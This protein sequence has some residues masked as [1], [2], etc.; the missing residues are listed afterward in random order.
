MSEPPAD[1]TLARQGAMHR[2]LSQFTASTVGY[3]RNNDR[4]QD[5][6]A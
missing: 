2:S 4:A 5:A 3:K 6:L 1:L